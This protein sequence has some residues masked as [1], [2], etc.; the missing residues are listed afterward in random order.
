MGTHVRSRYFAGIDWSEHWVDATVID[1]DGNVLLEQRIVYAAV[2]DPAQA[3]L[4]LL[5]QLTRS[6]RRIVTGIEELDLP[7]VRGLAAKDLSVVHVDPTLAARHRKAE[8]IAKSD[9]AD[10]RLI[11]DLVRRGVYRSPV[12]SS[13]LAQALRI[14]ALAQRAAALDRMA[15]LHAL[16]A[17]LARAWPAAVA[18]W[19]NSRGGLG[20]RQALSVLRAAPGPRPAEQL[21]RAE[22]ADLLSAA[23]RMRGTARE[24]ERLHLAFRNPAVLSDPEVEAA[25]AIRILDLVDAAAFAIARVVRLESEM[26]QRYARHRYHFATA[27]I[28][29]IGPVLGAQLLAGIGDRPV[30]RFASGRDLAAYAG[31]SPVTW[32]SGTVTRVSFRRSSSRLL[33]SIMHAAAFSWSRHSPGAHAYY[34]R[35]REAGDAH[36]TALRKLGR[37]LVLC[38]YYCM[39]THQPYDESR[40]FRHSADSTPQF[41]RRPP[42]DEMSVSRARELLA[43]PGATIA[44]TARAFGVSD[45]TIRR[46]VLGQPRSR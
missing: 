31:V 30:E 40:A 34:R 12:E 46:H 17:V 41:G 10:A 36:A 37:R 19:P 24:A 23:G 14:V 6:W 13:P 35:R 33:R 29:G 3:Y 1:R 18:A 32:S 44:G 27:G 9:R 21:S 8:G 28:P 42:L 7:I 5:R 45:Q 16:R 4:D 15:A 26:A 39:A 38:L 11:A 25:L 20:S 22:L 43:L 2:A